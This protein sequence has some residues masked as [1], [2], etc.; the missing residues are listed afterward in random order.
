MDAFALEVTEGLSARWVHSKEKT[1]D[2]VSV[3]FDEGGKATVRIADRWFASDPDFPTRL[4]GVG[5]FLVFLH[6]LQK[7]SGR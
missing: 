7:D 4:V 3:G 2:V 5:V 6:L 1:S